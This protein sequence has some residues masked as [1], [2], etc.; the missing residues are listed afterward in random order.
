M[1]LESF[2]VIL[3]AGALAGGVVNGLAGFGTGITAMGIWLYAV[4]PTVAATLV[5][6]CSLVAQLQTLPKIRHA[7]ELK[8]VVPFIV[9]G[10]IGVPLGTALLA[11]IDVRTFKLGI[12]CLLLL[13]ATHSLLHRSRSPVA[14][15]GRL[16]DGA[17]GLGGGILGGLAGL[18]GPL[19]TIWAD[20]RGWTKD[21]RRSVFQVFNITIC[22]AALASHFAAGLVTKELGIAVAAA[23]PGTF[24]G[25]FLGSALYARVNDKRFKEIILAL[26]GVSGIILVWTNI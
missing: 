1:G 2:V 16:A 25:A 7:I 26:L 23:L 10:L 11:S 14:W 22:S 17:V 4:S 6:V 13:Y 3:V 12:G 8:R 5:I 15:G 20:V 9:P 21:Q 18:S 19:P 24:A